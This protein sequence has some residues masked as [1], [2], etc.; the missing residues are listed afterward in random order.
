MFG[1]LAYRGKESMSY[2]L[3]YLQTVFEEQRQWLHLNS[4]LSDTEVRLLFIGV[5]NHTTN[6]HTQG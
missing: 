6:E 2:F 4:C 1:V 5:M 3:Q